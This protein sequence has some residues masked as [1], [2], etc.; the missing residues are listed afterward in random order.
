MY[1]LDNTADYSA[2][3]LDILARAYERAL[4]KLPPSD[5]RDS[6]AVRAALLA[7]ILD[8]AR[9]GIWDVEAL[10]ASALARAEARIGAMAVAD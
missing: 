4:E 6:G 5:G 7:G 10:K 8:A 9:R 1:R 2:V 3:Q